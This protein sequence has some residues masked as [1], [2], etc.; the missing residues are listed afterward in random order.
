[1][2]TV[3]AASDE[4]G[5]EVEIQTSLERTAVTETVRP[6]FAAMPTDPG[7]VNTIGE[8]MKYWARLIAA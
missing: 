2:I 6:L 1:M 5:L 4:A 7:M 8:I 3:S